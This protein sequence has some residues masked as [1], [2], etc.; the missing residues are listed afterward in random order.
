MGSSDDGPITHPAFPFDAIAVVRYKSP[1]ATDLS[2]A[3]GARVRVTALS[4]RDDEWFFGTLDGKSGDFPADFVEPVVDAVKAKGVDTRQ[5][6]HEKGHDSAK[7]EVVSTPDARAD[8]KEE[9]SRAKGAASGPKASRGDPRRQQ[10]FDQGSADE[11]DQWEDEND[12]DEDVNGSDDSS[13]RS[14][15]ETSEKKSKGKSQPSGR[16]QATPSKG[17][18]ALKKDPEADGSDSYASQDSSGQLACLIYPV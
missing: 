5:S 11:E 4:E 3:K 8:V 14:D 12:D 6:S 7:D 1:H 18:S 13:G 9:S 10:S 16:E 2:F 17:R 15:G